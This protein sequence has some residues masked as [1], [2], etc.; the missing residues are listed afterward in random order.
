MKISL[1]NISGQTILAELLKEVAKRT[2]YTWI[3]GHKAESRTIDI[4]SVNAGDTSLIGRLNLIQPNQIQLLGQTEVDYITGLSKE[5]YDGALE[6]LFTDTTLLIIIEA[7]CNI[8]KDF[9]THSEQSHTGLIST[10]LNC[11]DL[12][13]DLHYVLSRFYAHSETHHGVYLEVAGKGVFIQGLAGIGKSEVA[14]ELVTRGHRL[15]ADDA[16]D[17]TRT[18]PAKINGS[19]SAVL[20]DFL[21]VRGLGILNIKSLYGDNA[22]KLN[23]NLTL[24]IRLVEAT[25]Q[26]EDGT[27]TSRLHGIH[28][29]V[30]IIG[31]PFTRTTL[32]VAPGRNLAVMIEVSVKNHLIKLSGSDAFDDLHERLI[33]KMDAESKVLDV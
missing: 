26:H 31:V 6:H 18:G 10:P 17:F 30:D 3:A 33:E 5:R 12:L 11:N 28:D 16:V 7:S 4:S 20:Q 25:T 8:P 9:I 23:K 19:S 15:I 14:L 32:P 21:E 1:S 2:R 27:T 24:V 22:I 13:Y 29:E